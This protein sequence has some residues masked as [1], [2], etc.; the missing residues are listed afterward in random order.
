MTR[1]PSFSR[2]V[3]AITVEANTQ[4]MVVSTILVHYAFGI[5][6]ILH[7][8]MIDRLSYPVRSSESL[9]LLTTSDMFRMPSCIAFYTTLGA[10]SASSWKLTPKGVDLVIHSMEEV[11]THTFTLVLPRE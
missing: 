10:Q 2:R 4:Q 1:L 7:S 9:L 3:R 11:Q 5:T 6:L 8:M